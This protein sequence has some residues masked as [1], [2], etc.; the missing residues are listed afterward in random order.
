MLRGL[1]I[2]VGLAAMAACVSTAHAGTGGCSAADL[3]GDD[4]VTTSDLTAFLGNFGQTVSPGTGGDITGDGQVTT[5]DLT[6]FLGFFGET[7]APFEPPAILITPVAFEGDPAPDIELPG[8]FLGVILPPQIDAAGNVYFRSFLGGPNLDES[9]NIAL[10]HG[11]PNNPQ[12]LIWESDPAPDMPP[13]TIITSLLG[14]DFRVSEEGVVSFVASVAG[15]GI[16][17]HV[18]DRIIYWGPPDDLQVVLQTGDQAPGLPAGVTLNGEFGANFGGVVSDNSL[19]L[20]VSELV[21]PGIDA[22]N[23]TRTLWYGPHD[24]LQLAYQEGMQAPGA[25]PGEVLGGWSF[26]AFNASGQMAF[27]GSLLGPGITD[28]NNSGLWLGSPGNLELF[29]RDSWPAPGFPPE[30]T[31][32][33]GGGSTPLINSFGDLNARGRMQGPGITAENEWVLW[34][35]ADGEPT[36]VIRYGDLVPE[37]GPG[38]RVALLGEPLLND[39]REAFMHIRYTGP[40][41]DMTNRDAMYYGPYSDIHPVL[42]DGE[43]APAM[44]E[45]VNLS[46]VVGAF[47]TTAMNDVG[48]IV[49]ST[50]IIDAE[51][52]ETVVLWFRDRQSEQWYPLIRSGDTIGARTVAIERATDFSSRYVSITGGADGNGRSFNDNGQLI[53]RLPFSDGSEGVFVL[54]P[55]R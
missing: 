18:N 53:L 17:Q 32:L 51:L 43:P 40:S 36:Q 49:C 55:N 34:I 1:W 29:L 39:Q 15:P 16:T 46:F 24:D 30:I 33:S 5:S 21:G 10:F 28:D 19:L 13:G 26:L 25:E 35:F 20:V 45:G 2:G 23:D 38:V 27:R 42:R 9:N 3:T 31:L 41:I 4:A 52:K 22:S 54:Q 8:T 50:H 44:P 11:P 14:T 7:C 48:D 6:A 12:K 47:G 37:A